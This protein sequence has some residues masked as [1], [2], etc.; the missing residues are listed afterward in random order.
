MQESEQ[1]FPPHP[2]SRDILA[3]DDGLAA[4]VIGDVG[5]IDARQLALLAGEDQSLVDRRILH[6][7]VMQDDAGDARDDF[8]DLGAVLVGYARRFLDQHRHQQHALV[9]HVIVLDELCQR[10]R[11]ARGRGRHEHGGAGEPRMAA[12][13]GG[14]DQILFRL[15]QV[16]ACT[17]H[18]LDAA[19][20][21]QHHEGDDGGEQ[22]RKPAALEQLDRIGGEENAVDGEEESVDRDND[23][24]RIAPLDRHQRRQ[25]RGDG[26]QQRY[27]DA[28]G[29]GEGFGGAEV[30]H[31]A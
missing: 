21:G 17:L 29:T 2:H 3:R 20:P 19:A 30:Q 8:D 12:V 31:G 25:Q 15:A 5:E 28:V 9:Q 23:E 10:Q 6:E 4:D 11:H 22:Q 24:R 27:G 26:H 16:S 14:L 1:R 18:Q 13:D 7:A